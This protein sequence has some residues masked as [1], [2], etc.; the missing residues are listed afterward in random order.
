M[1]YDGWMNGAALRLS[2]RDYGCCNTVLAARQGLL[3]GMEE[4]LLSD[5]GGG[6]HR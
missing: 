4:K 1:P 5:V 6:C 3:R 2:R